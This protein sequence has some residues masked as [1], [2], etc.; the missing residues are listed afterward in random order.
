MEENIRQCAEEAVPSVGH[1]SVALVN[2]YQRSAKENAVS[3]TNYKGMRIHA[4]PGLHEFVASKLS[5]LACCGDRALDLAAGAGAMSLRLKEMGFEVTAT[6]LVPDNFRLHGTIPF[7]QTNLNADFSRQFERKFSVIMAL[8]IIEHLENPRHFLRECYKNLEAG[9]ILI[10]STPNVDNP[11]SRAF[12]VRYGNYLWFQDEDY[13]GDG[14]I[15]PC[16]GTY[17]EKCIRETGFESEW[18]SSFGNPFRHLRKWPKLR[19]LAWML[20]KISNLPRD[21]QGEVLTMALRKPA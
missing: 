1:D 3:H 2:F 19:F 18:I 17:L 15:T 16:L 9:G 13:F 20:A 14:H 21:L 4:L 8:E 10:L 5:D 12:L 6:D 11:V 7:A